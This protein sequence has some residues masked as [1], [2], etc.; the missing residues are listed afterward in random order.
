ML[1]AYGSAHAVLGAALSSRPNEVA[2]IVAGREAPPPPWVVRVLGV[3]LLAQGVAELLCPTF[4]VLLCAAGIDA[5]HAASM[6]GIATDTRH[7]KSA[8]VSAVVAGTSASLTVWT[9]LRLRR[10]AN[11]S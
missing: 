11:L 3:R 9:V 5:L 8:I 7:R 6:M 2:H 4:R 1:R 10:R